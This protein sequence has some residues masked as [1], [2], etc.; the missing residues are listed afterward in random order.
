LGT[1]HR[2]PVAVTKDA[3]WEELPGGTGLQGLNLAAA[4]GKV[5][6]IGG[7]QSRNKL[8]EKGDSHS[9]AEVMAFDPK[10]MKWSSAPSL[11]SGRSSHDV[12]IAGEK[13]VVVGGWEMKGPDEKPVWHE[14]VLILDTAAKDPHWESLPQPFK[15]RALTASAL[16]NKVYV[17]GGLNDAGETIRKVSVLDLATGKW[18]DGPEIP[19]SE[20]AGFSPASTVVGGKLVLN[21]QDKSVYVLNDKG[22]AWEKVGNTVESRLVHRLVPAGKDAVIAI[23]GAGPKGSYYASLERVKLDGT[24]LSVAPAATV[25]Q[26]FCPVMTEDEIDPKA[27][28]VVEYKGVKIY[29]CCDQ[30]VGRFKRDPIAYLD[31]KI[32][33]GLAGMELPKRDIEQ[34]FCPVL[35]DRKISSK[36]PS[37]TYKGVK[38][39]FYNDIARQRFEKDP[40]RYADLAILPQLK[41][42]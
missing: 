37:I 39:Y 27:S 32:I 11:P 7:M 1:F 21:T 31:A 42:K 10:T 30:C 28:A 36:D 26:K 14:T 20:K 9:L 17:M 41:G 2:L 6:R 25:S 3:K 5:Y 24:S 33:P 35:K 23:A 22:T 12:T 4:G 16:G 18:S 15:R 40:E 8:G 38:I 19:G 34:V 13:L 29:L